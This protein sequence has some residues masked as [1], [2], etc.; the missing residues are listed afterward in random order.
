MDRDI[1]KS[2]KAPSAKSSNAVGREHMA[3]KHAFIDTSTLLHY[4]HLREIDWVTLTQGGEVVLVLAPVVRR[5]ISSHKDLHPQKRARKRAADVA[6]FCHEQWSKADEYEVAL[7]EG[8]RLRFEPR[9]PMLDFKA[10]GLRTELQDDFLVASM[11]EFKTVHPNT[12]VLLVTADLD[13][14]VKASDHGFDVL[15]LPDTCRRPEEPDEGLATLQKKVA[16]YESQRPALRLVACAQGREL[17]NG[18]AVTLSIPRPVTSE[19]LL[20]AAHFRASEQAARARAHRSSLASDWDSEWLYPDEERRREQEHELR[21]QEAFA[22]EAREVEREGREVDVT[23]TIHN[24]G[25]APASHVVVE[26]TATEPLEVVGDQKAEAPRVMHTMSAT[27]AAFKIRFPKRFVADGARLT[28]TAICAETA[29]VSQTLDLR[30]DR[31]AVEPFRPDQR[32]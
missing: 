26:V 28:L 30:V 15:H 16:E 13:L 24:D 29:L 8:V 18:A 27:L 12:T 11:L 32:H 3:T 7:K 19:D 25:T 1:M 9:D 17:G 5:E 20:M 31:V 4:Q 14:T 2:K 21:L 10:H 22:E 23:V 6:R